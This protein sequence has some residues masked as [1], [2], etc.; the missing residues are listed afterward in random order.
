LGVG[1]FFRC[2]CNRSKVPKSLENL[3]AICPP[4]R[5]SPAKFSSPPAWTVFVEGVLSGLLPSTGTFFR[6]LNEHLIDFYIK[7]V[8]MNTVE[9]ELYD[10]VREKIGEKESKLLLQTIETKVASDLDKTKE[11]LATKEDMAS[12]RSEVTDLKSNVTNLKADVADLKADVT[13]LKADV[14]DLKADVV[15]LKANVTNLKAD[16]TDLKADVVNLKEGMTDLKENMTNL[17]VDI[18]N[19][20]ADLIKWMFIFWAGMLGSL[21][22][23][24]K[25]VGAF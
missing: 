5:R 13:D 3:K 8:I 19:V 7:F 15:N 20:K 12:I 21:I 22:G 14:T 9:L 11:T 23:I 4:A 16:V 25:L 17:K 24:L 10:A 1:F 18:A 6:L 2:F